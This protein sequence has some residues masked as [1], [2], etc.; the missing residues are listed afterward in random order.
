MNVRQERSLRHLLYKRER[1]LNLGKRVRF[2]K[3]GDNRDKRRGEA[4]LGGRPLA[5]ENRKR[6]G[7]I[8]GTHLV[9]SRR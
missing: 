9:E 2:L 1:S 6:V 7:L 3:L 4:G 8:R 5:G